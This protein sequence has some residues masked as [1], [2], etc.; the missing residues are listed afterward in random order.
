MNTA[1]QPDLVIAI[2]TTAARVATLTLARLPPQS[3]VEYRIFVQSDGVERAIAA[4]AAQV[5]ARDDIRIIPTE[6]HGAA[7]NRNAA[8][9]QIGGG[10]L[11][12]ADDDLTFDLAGIS[13]LRTRIA[14]A[15]NIDFFCARL[16]DGVNRSA[17]RY[18]PD[19]TAVRWYNCGK[20]GT[21]ELAL[22]PARARAAGLRFDENFGAGTPNWLGDE[23]IF[24]CDA[25]RAGLQGRHVAV[26]IG[27]HP[28]DSSGLAKGAAIMAV[29]RKVLVRALG[30][31][32][33][34]PAR[35]A[36]ALRHRRDF[37]NLASFLWFL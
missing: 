13:T 14:G 24:L 27:V 4:H 19:C 16:L 21:P 20:V 9:D 12:F 15:P 23:Y 34:M 2:A 37:P 35:W 36:F 17:K 1:P 5:L 31:W 26:D 22:H 25:L 3:G 18:A 30:R 11:L 10:V 32:R 29:R 7:R 6:G 28:A 33:G 8:L